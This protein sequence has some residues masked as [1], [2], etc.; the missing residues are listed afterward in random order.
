MATTVPATGTPQG[1]QSNLRVPTWIL[2]TLMAVSGIVWV[3]F[4]LVHLF[5]NL[6]VFAGAQSFN[7][8]AHWLRHAL[9]PLLPEGF[10]L[11]TLRVAL[12]A[13]LA[14]HVWGAAALWRRGRRA[15]GSFAAHSRFF[16][17]GFQA[18]AARLMPITG[19]VVLVFLVV[20]I[21]DLTTGTPGVASA[22]FVPATE[23]TSMA[24]ENLIASLQRPAMA[25]FYVLVMV[26]LAVHVSHGT[27]MV[28]TDLGAMGYRLRQ[29]AVIVGGALGMIILIGNGAIPICVQLGVLS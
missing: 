16:R 2:K 20:H 6:K 18:V 23:A 9:S 21:M 17:G 8:Y 25:G 12:V 15:R 29:G 13:A 10:L 5:G 19:V 3:V 26:L 4:V 28:A 11:W 27:V 22:D 1:R 14:V 7:S 24:Y